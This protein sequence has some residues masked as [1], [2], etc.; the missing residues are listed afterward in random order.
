MEAKEWVT[1]EEIDAAYA[2]GAAAVKAL[3]ARVTLVL[4]QLE[5]RLQALEDQVAKNSRNSGKP[6]SSDGLKKP[7]VK[8]QRER[9]GKPSGGQKGHG[10]QRLEYAATPD[11]TL[12]HRLNRC[13]YCQADLTSVAANEVETRQVFD[14]P[15]VRLLVTEHQAEIKS[16]PACGRTSQAAF[17]CD[18]S[19]PTQ[20]GPHFRAQLVYFH[21][22]HFIPLARTV[23]VVEGLYGQPVS[24]GTIVAA[25]AE[26]ARR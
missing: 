22:G 17:P 19:A 6:P 12:V 26:V 20:Y 13:A 11:A 4:A 5:T 14:L 24:E 16:C 18:V 25:V 15:V 23:E 2:Q 21:S 9:S 3:F 7:V 1:A 8:S 10:G